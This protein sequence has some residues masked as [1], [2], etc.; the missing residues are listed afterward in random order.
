MVT[1]K[2]AATSDQAMRWGPRLV[3]ARET[4]TTVTVTAS[5]MNATLE[6]MSSVLWRNGSA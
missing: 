5:D 4:D 3:R 6:T 2:L 1:T